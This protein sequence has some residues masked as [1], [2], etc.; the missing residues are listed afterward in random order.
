MYCSIRL[1]SDIS[2]LP[3]PLAS[4]YRILSW[5]NTV[6]ASRGS[7]DSRILKASIKLDVYKRQGVGGVIYKVSIFLQV[8]QPDGDLIIL[9]KGIAVEV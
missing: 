1:T 8:L 7:V 6:R 5:A 9:G 2:T 4:P 3:L